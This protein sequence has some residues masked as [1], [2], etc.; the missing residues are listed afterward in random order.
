VDG[1][2]FTQTA[3]AGPENFTLDSGMHVYA[4]RASDGQQYYRH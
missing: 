4:F 2:I 1:V 3:F